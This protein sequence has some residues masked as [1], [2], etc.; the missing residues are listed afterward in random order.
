MKCNLIKGLI[1]FLFI[2]LQ[3]SNIAQ[4]TYQ[5]TYG[6]LYGEKGRTVIQTSDNCYVIA[7]NSNSL[8]S[9]NT[10]FYLLKANTSGEIIW[11]KLYSSDN[12]MEFAVSIQQTNDYGFIIAGNTRNIANINSNDIALIKTDSIGNI[13]WSKTL[14]G[15][16]QD[17]AFSV[18][19]TFDNGF[20]VLGST[21]NFGNLTGNTYLIKTDI[22]GNILWSKIYDSG[23]TER[24]RSIISTNDSGFLI[25]SSSPGF[26]GSILIKTDIYGDVQ[27]AKKYPALYEPIEVIQC[28]DDGYTIVGNIINTSWDIFL[29]RTDSIGNVYWAKAYGGNGWDEGYS[30]RQTSNLDYI[31]VGYS[32]SFGIAS[33]GYAIKTDYNGNLQWSNIYGDD[34]HDYFRSVIVTDGG[35][36]ISGWIGSFGSGGYDLWLIKTDAN[37]NSGCNQTSVETIVTTLDI[38]ADSITIETDTGFEESNLILST[39]TLNAVETVLCITTN[40]N[41]NDFNSFEAL[42]YPNPIT[43]I[44]TLKFEYNPSEIFELRIYNSNGQIVHQITEITAGEIEIKRNDLDIGIYF[45][46]L[47]SSNKI[48]GTWKV[49]IN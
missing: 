32:N 9:D 7:G 23:N 6:G 1:I 2:T 19:Q 36:L 10:N 29:L 15:E 42:L 20:V 39:N 47:Q 34:G 38:L 35:F 33:D 43:E 49:I 24:G 27:W 17:W 28:L 12:D 21:I 18:Q 3:Q 48:I 11:D 31:I 14:G 25:V 30:V 8:N 44:S 22:S 16:Y 45:I 4:V 41:T 46:Q 26:S 37:G 5:K 13:E 40:I